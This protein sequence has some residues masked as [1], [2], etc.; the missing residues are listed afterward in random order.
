MNHWW[1]RLSDSRR[2][3]TDWNLNTNDNVWWEPVKLSLYLDKHPSSSRWGIHWTNSFLAYWLLGEQWLNIP[4][5]QKI[6]EFS[7]LVTIF[8]QWLHQ[9]L[10]CAFCSTCLKLVL[11][12][13][14][15]IMLVLMVKGHRNTNF[16]FTEWFYLTCETEN[17]N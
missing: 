10:L 15:S 11:F 3:T 9:H 13:M 1:K 4:L 12:S 16:D 5:S 7:C 14:F 17:T 8:L 6:M 2:R